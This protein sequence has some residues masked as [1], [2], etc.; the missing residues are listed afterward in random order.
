MKTLYQC[1]FIVNVIIRRKIWLITIALKSNSV[2]YYYKTI[3]LPEMDA[4]CYNFPYI[5]YI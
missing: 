2:P 4:I 3:A 1:H 5:S